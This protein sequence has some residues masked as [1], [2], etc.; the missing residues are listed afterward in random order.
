[1]TCQ[2]LATRKGQKQGFTA[3]P[4]TPPP[5]CLLKSGAMLSAPACKVTLEC[6]IMNGSY[7]SLWTVVSG[8]YSERMLT[9]TFKFLGGSEI[10]SG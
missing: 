10:S 6:C 5:L 9:I 3:F 4:D 8:I 2:R 7:S 1:M